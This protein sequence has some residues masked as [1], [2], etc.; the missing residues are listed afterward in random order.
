MKKSIK[1]LS[2]ILAMM[3]LFSMTALFTSCAKDVEEETSAPVG[4]VSTD[5]S[6]P[7]LEIKDLGGLEIKLLWPEM[8][9]DGHYLHNELTGNKE[10]QGDVIDAAVAERNA[11]VEATYNVKLTSDTKFISTIPKDIQTEAM[12]Q[13]ASYNVIASTI[14]FMTPLAQEGV[15]AA[16]NDLA[17]Y[18]ESHPWWNHDLMQDFSIA[19]EKY[20]GSGDIIYSDDFYP[21]C[22][23][24]NSKVSEEQGITEDYYE[25]V[26]TKQWTLEKF[27]Q[28]SAQVSNWGLSGEESWDEGDMN[29]AVI[30]ENF[31]RAA[32][33]SAGKGMIDFTKDGYPVWQMTVDRT[34]SILEKLIGVIFTDN[35]CTNVGVFDNHVEWELKLF[36]GNQGLFMVEELISSERMTK[37][38]S[39]DFKVLPFPLYEEGGEYISVLNDALILSVPVYSANKDD[40]SLVLSAM[41]RESVNT[42]TPAFFETVLTYRYMQDAQSVETLSLILDSVVAPD[43]ATIQDWGAFMKN[44][45]ALVF[46]QSTDFSSYHAQHIGEAMDKVE[47]YSVMIDEFYAK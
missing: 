16:Y 10:S 13:E 2:V 46:E 23:Y 20:F 35:A 24:L 6:L 3:M 31:A 37:N 30:N 43:V 18:D 4:T 17:Y 25:L 27:H 45:K 21:Y 44:F 7:E 9:A 14:K 5:E 32:Y 40:V 39:V 8:H 26:N 22:V 38:Y 12:A 11:I 29:G 41:G 19:N 1:L 33:Y 15:L 47:E 28:L 36:T 42:L 34:Q